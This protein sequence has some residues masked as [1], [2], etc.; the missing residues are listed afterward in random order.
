MNEAVSP[1]PAAPATP[2][3]ATQWATRAAFFVVGLT[4]SAWAPLIPHARQRLGVDEAQLGLLLLCMGIGSVLVMP[5]AG[6]LA[7]RFGCRRMQLAAGALICLSLPFLAV[8]ATPAGLA[9]ALLGMGAGLGVFNVVVNVQAVAV[10]RAAARAMM[11]GFHGMFSVGGIAG[12]GGVSVLIG[13]GASPLL[14]ASVA[15]ALALLLLAV[16]APAMLPYGG[17]SGRAAFA[18]PRGKVLLIGAICF[19]MFLAEGSVLDWGALFLTSNRHL[20]PSTAG[21]GYVAFASAM[22]LGRLAGDRIVQMLGATRVVLFGGVVAACGLLLAVLLPWGWAGLTGFA[23][24]GIGAANVVPVMFSAAGR[25]HDMPTHLAIAAVTTLG[26][27][28]VLLGPALLGFVAKLTGLPAALG[29][30]A[31]LLALAA[32]GARR[33]TR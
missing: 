7:A 1:I 12:A 11:P 4:V 6:G 24:V 18:R 15:T 28:G 14:A 27:A 8:A 2:G 3:V 29:L 10:E 9:L 13:L 19:V 20:P 26:Y 22:T 23:L 16:S 32:S 30:V 21:F 25:Q 33:A 31:L 17:E 5:L